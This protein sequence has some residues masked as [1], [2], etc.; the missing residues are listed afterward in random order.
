VSAPSGEAWWLR[1]AG[2]RRLRK[3]QPVNVIALAV[4]AFG[5]GLLV[6]MQ[7]CDR[8][9]HRA[10]YSRRAFEPPPLTWAEQ[11]EQEQVDWQEPPTVELHRRPV[12]PVARE[13]EHGRSRELDRRW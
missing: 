1:A 2:V 11:Q 9:P 3:G 12:L 10:F 13:L 8:L 5:V 6:V 7:L 4:I